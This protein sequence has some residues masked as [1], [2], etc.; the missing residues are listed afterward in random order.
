MYKSQASVLTSGKK[1]AKNCSNGFRRNGEDKGERN[2]CS[3]LTE[4]FYLFCFL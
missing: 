4:L 1:N 3:T 2:R